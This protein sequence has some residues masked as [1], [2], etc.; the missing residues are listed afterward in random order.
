MLTRIGK[1]CP[2]Y[3]S[4]GIIKIIWLF[5][6]KPISLKLQGFDHFYKDRIKITCFL[7]NHD[8]YQYI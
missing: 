3:E 5:N 6:K 1:I 8:I 2:I 7:S 4:S